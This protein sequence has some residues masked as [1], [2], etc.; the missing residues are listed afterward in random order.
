MD[1]IQTRALQSL[2]RVRHDIAAECLVLLF[3]IPNAPGSNLGLGNWLLFLTSQISG[4]CPILKKTIQG[5]T[6]FTLMIHC[7]C[8]V[9]LH[10][11][12]EP[13]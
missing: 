1:Q 10:R 9:I 5:S 12:E 2:K 11:E 7:Y 8:E 4:K 3:H 13:A 6:V